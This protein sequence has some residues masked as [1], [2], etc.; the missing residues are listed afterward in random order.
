MGYKVK[1]VPI[2]R[3]SVRGWNKNLKKSAE[4]VSFMDGS[5]LGSLVGAKTESILLPH[6]TPTQGFSK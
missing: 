3:V 5:I 1:K 2:W 4:S 6:S